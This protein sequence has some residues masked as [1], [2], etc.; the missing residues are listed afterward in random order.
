M[1]DAILV[2]TVLATIVFGYF[3]VS[4]IDKFIDNNQKAISRD[5]EKT[6]PSHIMLTEDTPD[7][8]I[9]DE[10]K[11]FRD[12]HKKICIIICEETDAETDKRSEYSEEKKQ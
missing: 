6:E 10:V 2:I 9:L 11:R 8:V 4:G 3:V 5:H 7:D 12:S 1:K